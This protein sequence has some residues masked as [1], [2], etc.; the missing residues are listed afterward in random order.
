MLVAFSAAAKITTDRDSADRGSTNLLAFLLLSGLILSLLLGANALPRPDLY[1]STGFERGTSTPARRCVRIGID[2][3]NSISG[4]DW[5]VVTA[6]SAWATGTL[7]ENDCTPSCAEGTYQTHEVEI[8]ASLPA[9]CS[10]VVYHDYSDVTYTVQ[11]DVFMIGHQPYQVWG[12]PCISSTGVPLPP[13][14]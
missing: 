13:V 1:V 6:E 2:N 14:T 7:N 5:S 12:Q 10:V 8:V 9:S 4:L 11:A 3:H